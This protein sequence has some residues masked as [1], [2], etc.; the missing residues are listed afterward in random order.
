[1]V[2]CLQVVDIE[3]NKGMDITYVYKGLK[4]QGCPVGNFHYRCIMYYL[5]CSGLI[6]E[7]SIWILLNTV[8][9]ISYFQGIEGK[10]ILARALT[11]RYA[12]K[13]FMLDQSLGLYGRITE[14]YALK[15][16]ML[17]QS[18]GLYWSFKEF[19]LDKSFGLYQKCKIVLIMLIGNRKTSKTKH[20]IGSLSI[21]CFLAI[22]NLPA[23]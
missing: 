9:V 18:L 6:L 7:K 23:R 5:R 19:M 22:F 16:F 15:E 10:Y 11:E 13:E 8:R 14:R 3:F 21:V 1:M 12:P 20:H 2:A 4:I 17:D